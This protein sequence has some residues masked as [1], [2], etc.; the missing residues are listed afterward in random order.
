M[1]FPRVTRIRSDKNWETATNLDELRHLFKT[2][3]EKTD[4]TLLNKLAETASKSDMTPKISK[5]SPVKRKKTESD[6]DS[7]GPSKAVDK[8]DSGRPNKKVKRSPS[9]TKTSPAEQSQ[10]KQKESPRDMKTE[11]QDSK[12]KIKQSPGDSKR[13]HTDESSKKSKE[14]PTKL[15]TLDSYFSKES[16]GSSATKIKKERASSTSSSDTIGNLD[17]KHNDLKKDDSNA[18]SATEVYFSEASTSDVEDKKEIPIQLYPDKPL[19]DA[20]KDKRIG[21]YPD[22][23]SFPEEER[24]HFER[25]WIAYGGKVVKSL[26][27]IDVDYLVHKNDRIEFRKMQKLKSKLGNDNVRHVTKDWLNECINEVKL[28]DTEKFPVFVDP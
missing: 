10:K 12:I 16:K 26:K 21:F 24:R 3:K 9:E 14:S 4:V 5:E 27:S 22:F 18:S 6:E 8:T 1:R 19:P 2:S 13:K 23:I 20:F 11:Q 25:H 15:K 17:G 7:S 28:C